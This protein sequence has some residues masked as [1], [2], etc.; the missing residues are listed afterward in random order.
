MR[1]KSKINNIQ[2]ESIVRTASEVTTFSGGGT[3]ANVYE[4][5]SVSEFKTLLDLL[6]DKG[7]TPFILGGGSNVIVA[8]GVVERTVISTKRMN[9][10][11]IENGLVFAECGAKISDIARQAREYDLGGLEF[12]AGVPLTLGGALKMNAS[13]FGREIADF[14]QSAFIFSSRACDTHECDMD[15]IGTQCTGRARV[16]I[17]RLA[18]DEI[19]FAYRR[20][21]QKVVLGGVLK[22]CKIESAQSLETARE[23]TKVRRAKQPREHS[24]GSVFKNGEIPSGKLIEACGLKGRQIGGAKISEKHANFIVNTGGATATDFLSL[25]ETCEREVSQKFGIKLERE[26]VLLK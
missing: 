19:D 11:R 24:C 6:D 14:L 7:E 18:R 23:Y 20:G 21:V 2:I 17:C 5:T 16:D 4:P 8:D 1:E 9:K 13:A 26:F 25:V 12:L 15:V 10:I 3:L 22:L